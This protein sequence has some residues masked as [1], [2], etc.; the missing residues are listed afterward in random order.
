MIPTS[1][2]NPDSFQA[3]ECASNIPNEAADI[4]PSTRGKEKT[5]QN[6]WSHKCNEELFATTSHLGGDPRTCDETVYVSISWKGCKQHIP[7]GESAGRLPVASLWM[8]TAVK[9]AII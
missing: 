9:A 3:L 1:V 4:Q 8:D 2:P 7:W 5:K 6:T